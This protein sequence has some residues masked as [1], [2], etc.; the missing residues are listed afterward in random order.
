MAKQTHISLLSALHGHPFAITEPGLRMI[1][2]IA[3][4]QVIDADLLREYKRQDAERPPTA[5]M[6]R[7][8]DKVEGARR[9][10]LRENGVGVLA[11]RGPMIRHADLFDEISGATSMA[12]LRQ[13]VQLARTHP[14]IRSLVLDIETPGGEIPAELAEAIRELDADKPVT[15]FIGNWGMSAGYWT[16]SGA[17]RL[18]AHRT[19]YTGSVGV[20]ATFVDTSRLEESQG[21]EIIEMMASQ[22]PDKIANPRTP[23]GKALIQQILD[24]TAEDFI[25]DVARYR[26]VSQKRVRTDFGKGAAVDAK[27]AAEIGMIDALDTMEGV[28]AAVGGGRRY[29][30]TRTSV[31]ASGVP[32][33]MPKTLRQMLSEAFGHR[34]DEEVAEDLPTVGS[35]HDAPAQASDDP[36]ELRRQL[37]AER[38]RAEAAEQER[39]AARKQ[40]QDGAITSQEKDIRAKVQ[41][42]VGKRIHPAERAAIESSCLTLARADRANGTSLLAE[43]QSSIE[44]R[45]VLNVTDEVVVSG[46]PPAGGRVDLPPVAPDPPEAG[47]DPW[48]AARAALVNQVSPD[49]RAALNGTTK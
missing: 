31:A 14:D 30:P 41:S 6:G 9:L 7:A 18:V 11:I 48:A 5:F 36:A 12:T 46:K 49:G 33:S 34:M 32:T 40:S 27:R 28:I 8:G 20:R 23:E 1:V 13:E 44:S 17:G 47:G 2:A 37:Q 25:G 19:A 3:S 26:N 38:Q 39:D 15:G 35:S 16:G 21:I 42:W 24:N 4:R 22:S 45:P 10:R 43:F 29:R